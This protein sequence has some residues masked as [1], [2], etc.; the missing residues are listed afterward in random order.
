MLKIR[1][2]VELKELKKFGFI[3]TSGNT[4]FAS[5]FN[6]G[7]NCEETGIV[8]NPANTAQIEKEIVHYTNND[9]EIDLSSELDV[10]YD[11]I[12]AD[13]VEKVEG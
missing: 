4:Y 10:L 8:V 5:T 2:D 1:D 6:T 9:D 11:L 13:L 3:N 7:D 12:K